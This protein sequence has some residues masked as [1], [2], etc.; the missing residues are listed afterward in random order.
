MWS[1]READP[2]R[3]PGSGA[4][5]GAAAALADGF[6]HGAGL[7]AVCWGFVER[8]PSGTLA[9]HDAFRGA[10]TP[11]EAAHRAAWF[12]SFGWTR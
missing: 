10:G 8:T 3:C 5:A 2:P 6:P 4:P 7:C 9:Q 11:E 1:D 12:N